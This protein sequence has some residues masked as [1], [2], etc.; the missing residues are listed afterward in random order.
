VGCHARWAGVAVGKAL[1]QAGHTGAMQGGHMP[2][3]ADPQ[4]DSDHLAAV[5]FYF[6]ISSNRYKIQ[7]FV[8]NWFEVKKKYETNF[9]G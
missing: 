1:V 5:F 7:N 8:Q 6:L 9:F 4:A 3:A 2:C